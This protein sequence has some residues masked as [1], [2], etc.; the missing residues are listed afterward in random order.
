MKTPKIYVSGPMT[1]IPEYNAPAFNALARRIKDM[2]LFCV[3]PIDISANIVTSVERGE[4]TMPSRYYFMRLDIQALCDCDAILML[5]GWQKSWGAKWERIIAKHVFDMPVLESINSLKAY[6]GI[7][8]K[9]KPT[10]DT[11]LDGF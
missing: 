11:L 1:G 7:V 8:D 10:F 4:I 9:L 2:G 6:Y 3:N 5:P